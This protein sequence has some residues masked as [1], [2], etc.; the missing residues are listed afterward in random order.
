MTI[1]KV[2]R[3]LSFVPAVYNLRKHTALLEVVMR[4]SILVRLPRTL[5]LCLPLALSSVV[6]LVGCGNTGG[7]VSTVAGTGV[8]G[9]SGDGAAAVAAELHNP[10]KIALDSAGNLYIADVGNNVVRM[11][12]ASAGIITTVAGN[13]TPG[14]SGNK[15][16]ATSAT[17]NSPN[18]VAVDSSGNLYVADTGNNVIRQVLASSGFI[19]TFAGNGTSGYSGD[20]GLATSATLK[21]P[22]GVALDSAGNLYIADTNN[23]VIR[24]VT[25]S[26]GI[27][28]TVAGNGTSGYSGDNGPATSATLISPN[29]VTVDPSGNIYIADT[30]NNVIRKVTASSAIIAT[31]VGSGK[32][33]YTGDNS[34]ATSATLNSPYDVALDSAGNIY[35]ADTGNNVIREDT[36]SSAII[37]TVVGSGAFGDTGAATSVTLKSPYGVA[38]DSAGDIYVADTGNNIIQMD[39]IPQ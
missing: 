37:A 35:I 32:S 24:E 4:S 39:T 9:F 13:G 1:V 29:G 3:Q 11:V 30:G 5:S 15:G 27:V 25:A 26:T 12:T 33:G 19:T 28:T 6:L 18:A 23:N 10:R 34:T 31:V 36:V 2:Q 17:L 16:P 38:L 7:T 14:Y 21:S 8:A 20:K 22:A